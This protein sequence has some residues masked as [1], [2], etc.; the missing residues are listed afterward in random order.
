MLF[1]ATL[2]ADYSTF[3]V[4]AVK[5]VQLPQCGNTRKDCSVPKPPETT[6]PVVRTLESAPLANV[7]GGGVLL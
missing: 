4:Q 3:W 6:N 7:S 5:S 2:V 1:S